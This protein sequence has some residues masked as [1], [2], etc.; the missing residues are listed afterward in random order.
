MKGILR[1][2]MGLGTL[3]FTAVAAAASTVT[4]YYNDLAGSPVVATNATGQVI[5]RESYQPYGGRTRNEPSSAENKVWFTSR[6][7]DAETGLV[8]MGA[9]YY[10]PLVGRFVSMD[11]A[12]FDEGNLHSFNR[13]AYANNNPYRYVD[14]DGKMAVPLGR[15]VFTAAYEAAKVVG[16][17]AFGSV[18][19]IGLANLVINATKAEGDTAQSDSRE[20]SKGEAKGDRE[21]GS[22]TN[23]HE[24]GK[25]YHGKGDRARSQQS[26]QDK[27]REHG[28]RHTATDWTPSSN[29]R[30]AFKDEA[31]RI[32]GDRGVSN[33]DNFN[34][35]NSPG[36]KYLD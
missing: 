33:P 20:L 34:K 22:Y 1:I 23:T 5:W 4:Y 26:G 29:D 36:K 27:E 32:Q 30:E 15:L 8:Y 21:A 28:D 14:P 6:R 31:R 7:Q 9:R 10:D 12:G 35:I 24:S 13:Y 2:G 3:L 19:G 16:L 17:P 11:P 25:K 18:L